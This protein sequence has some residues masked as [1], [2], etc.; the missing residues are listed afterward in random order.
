M[1]DV[2]TPADAADERRHDPE[3]ETY[4]SESWYLDFTDEAARLGGYVRLG[5]YPNLG[6]AWYWACV[7]GEGRPLVTVIDHEVPI[8]R[9]ASSR[10][11]PRACGPTTWSRPRSTTC[12]SASRRSP[13]ALDDPADVYRRPARRSDRRS[14]STSSGRPTAAPTPTRSRRVRDP[15]PGARRGAGGRRGDRLRRLGPARPLLGVRDWWTVD[16]SWTAGRLDDGTRFHGTDVTLGGDRVCR[17]RLRAAARRADRRGGRGR[18]G[19][20]CWLGRRPSRAGT[21]CASTTSP[22]PSSRWRSR[23]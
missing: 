20:A 22:S 19:P 15:V 1:A 12:R 8:P 9:T 13:S 6:G 7:V 11:A 17:H 4:W 5:L 3:G 21:W 18:P 14:A 10:S 23:R 16:W 2:A